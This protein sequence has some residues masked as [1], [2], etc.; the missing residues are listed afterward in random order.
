MRSY[1]K[2]QKFGASASLNGPTPTSLGGQ[3]EA[4]VGACLQEKI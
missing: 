1:F 3:I 4:G 2:K